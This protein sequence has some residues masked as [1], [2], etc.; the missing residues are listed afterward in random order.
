VRGRHF[1]E[2]DEH[3]VAL[4]EVYEPPTE[5]DT[6]NRE[7]RKLVVV[8]TKV[9]SLWYRT[10]DDIVTKRRGICSDVHLSG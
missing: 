6:W 2:V 8:N 7:G 1:S 10:Y 9:V 5:K 4:A 3:R